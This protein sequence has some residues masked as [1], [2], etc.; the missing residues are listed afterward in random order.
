MERGD[1]MDDVRRDGKGRDC[2]R[3]EEELG[4]RDGNQA[5]EMDPAV[6]LLGRQE[7][8]DVRFLGGGG[9]KNEYGGLEHLQ[10]TTIK[11]P[12]KCSFESNLKLIESVFFCFLQQDT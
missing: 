10:K 5:D 4:R 9:R 3:T 2:N 7:E 8:N 1:G 12:L 6:G 11:S